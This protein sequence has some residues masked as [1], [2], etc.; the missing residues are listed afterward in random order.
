M[1]VSLTYDIADSAQKMGSSQRWLVD[2]L[3]AGRLPGRKVAG[4]WRMTEQDIID[5]LELCSNR[6]RGI[7]A[8]GEEVTGLT[9]TSRKRLSGRSMRSGVDQ[10]PRQATG[11]PAVGG[12]RGTSNARITQEEK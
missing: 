5:A 10:Q 4:H 11:P 3:R 6:S 12:S 7:G 9:S 2:E 8:D 1:P